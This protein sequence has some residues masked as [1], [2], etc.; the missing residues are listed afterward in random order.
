MLEVGE[1]YLTI[2][3]FGG[4]I[5]LNAFPNKERKKNKKAPHFK[6]VDGIAVWVNSKQPPKENNTPKEDIL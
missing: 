1:K 4:Q 2:H 6:S 3:L 5:K